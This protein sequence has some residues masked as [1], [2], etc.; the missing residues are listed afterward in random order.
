MSLSDF[1]TVEDLFKQASFRQRA[2]DAY[3]QELLDLR[4]EFEE[5]AERVKDALVAFLRVQLGLTAAELDALDYQVNV[6]DEAANQPAVQVD[7][8]RIPLKGTFARKN[9]RIST[10]P[11]DGTFVVKTFE[12]RTRK[13]GSWVIVESL[14][15][16]GKLLSEGNVG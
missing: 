3:T 8:D 5:E 9:E 12:V 15:S 4:A 13:N 16:L 1:N 7:I 14:A 11:R 2:A 6:Q 10:D